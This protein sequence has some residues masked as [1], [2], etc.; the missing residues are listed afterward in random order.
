ME[1]AVRQKPSPEILDALDELMRYFIADPTDD[2]GSVRAA[3]EA[4]PGF[5]YLV[6]SAGLVKIG[7]A[8][9]VSRRLRQLNSQSA[10][11][12]RLLGAFRSEDARKSELDLHARY[13]AQRSHGE[14]F[15]LA[16]SDIEEICVA[17][18]C[19]RAR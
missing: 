8:S 10:V 13:R 3:D 11:P 15:R 19:E 17:V 12:V 18:G 1:M 6:E 4:I 14:W 16:A 5:V 9:D 7:I 2:N